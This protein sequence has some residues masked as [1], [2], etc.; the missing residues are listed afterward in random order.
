[1]ASQNSPGAGTWVRSRQVTYDAPL[2]DPK[3][4]FRPPAGGAQNAFVPFWAV[5]RDRPTGP[6][7]SNSNDFFD[8]QVTN[9]IPLA[10]T[11]ADGTGQ[12]SFEVETV[13]EA[14]GLGCGDPIIKGGATRGRSCWL[15]IVPRGNIEVDGSVRSGAND[16]DRLNSSPLSQSNWDNRIVVPLEFR[17]VD[18]YCPIGA[19]E[20][21]VIGH[22]LATDAVHSW[23]PA[24]CASG[25]ARYSYIQLS[26]DVT[27]SQVVGGAGSLLALTT[28]PIPP[29]QVPGDP[30]AGLRAGRVVWVGHRLRHRTPATREW[31][32]R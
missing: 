25:G 16:T 27:R 4:T 6:A 28:N 2:T 26:D 15:V 22:E 1:L 19:P 31:A 13:C 10:R 23:E 9:E 11:H 17:P 7:T 14:A 32:S 21:R 12:E 8:S 18:Q 30:S 5:G 3:E 20:R 29:D 24:L